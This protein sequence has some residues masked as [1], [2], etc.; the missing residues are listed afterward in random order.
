MSRITSSFFP[1][2]VAALLLF[3]RT[4]AFSV[5]QQAPQRS[6]SLSVLLSGKDGGEKSKDI[7]NPLAKSSWYAV[8]LFGKAFA[9]NK[10]KETAITDGPP[11]SLQETLLRIQKD[12]DRSYFLSGQVDQAIYDPNCV[13]SDPF[14]SFSGTERF[15]TNLA[16]LGSFITKYSAK[17]LQNEQLDDTTVQT[18]VS[19]RPF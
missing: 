16:N 11:Q 8:E 12:N 18:K 15:V 19:F 10:K 7:M 5:L 4:V 6:F 13:F 9:S 14:A 3:E 1:V 17:V 2:L